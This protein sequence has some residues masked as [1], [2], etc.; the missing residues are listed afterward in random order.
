MTNPDST[1]NASTPSQPKLPTDP[2][3]SS[4]LRNPALPRVKWNKQTASA[5]S[6]R[7]GSKMGML[8]DFLALISMLPH[9][10]K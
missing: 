3:G 7:S 1:K 5:A 10:T 4:S 2:T 8:F 9:H 6:P